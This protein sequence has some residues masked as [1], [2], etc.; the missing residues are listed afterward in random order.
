MHKGIEIL[1]CLFLVATISVGVLAK[2]DLARAVPT[3]MNILPSSIINPSIDPGQSI[4]I[5]ASVADVSDLYAWQITVF[6]A[7]GLLNCTNATLPSGHVFAGKTFI[8]VTPVI[9][10][11]GGSVIFGLTL[12]GSV[13]GFSGSGTLC[14]LGFAVMGRGVSNLNYSIPYGGDTFLEDSD[15]NVIPSLMNN[16]YFDNRIS[17]PEPQ[18]P[19]AAFDYSPKPVLVGQLVTFNGSA[20]YD[21][22]GTVVFWSWNFGDSGTGSGQLATHTYASE[23]NFTV[24]LA[25]FDNDNFTDSTSKV[26]SVYTSH[27]A[28]LYVDPPEIVD[29]TLLP[30]ALVS[31]NVT[32]NYVTN[33]YDYM[34]RLSYNTQ[35]LT[36]IG[37]IINRVQNQ[38]AF[39]PL[40]LIDDGAGYIWINVTYRSPAVPISTVTPLALVTIYF[41]IDELGS[42]V[43][44]LSDTELSDPAHN[45]MPHQTGDGFIMTLIR[46]VAITNVVPSTSWAYQGWPVDISVTAKNNGNISESFTVKAYYDS[47]LIGTAPVNNLPSNTDTTVTIHWDTTGVPEGNYTIAAEATLVPFEFNTTN[48]YLADGT[49]QIFMAIRDVAITGVTTS[50]SWVYPGVPVNITVTAK[51]TGDVTES[52]DVNV[53]YDTNLL[54]TTS[55]LNLLPGVETTLVFGWN[56]SALIPCNNYSISANASFVPFEYNLTN[57]V[58]YDGYVKIRWVGDINGDGKV[59]IKDV[60][61]VGQAFGTYPGH[62]RWNPDADITGSVYLVPDGKV[63]IRDVSLVSRNFG[64]GCT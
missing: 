4:I 18:P 46:D 29:P 47:T 2:A 55:I 1:L 14:Q 45:P 15:L 16:G 25:V 26:V 64:H 36:C 20:S 19:V 17:Q 54:A 61:I 34:F 39:T 27:P 24:T 56:T 28:Q 13:S 35:M 3:T 49:V 31:I 41:Q 40:I 42:S 11:V 12:I 58:F 50:R 38:T 30:P 7:P 10:N 52:F 32:V 21:P 63:D 22:D 60:S 57:N 8:E 43:L 6:F 59:D 23:G 5:N 44:H 37:A 53:Y 9:D 48:N 51:N 62:P 33:M